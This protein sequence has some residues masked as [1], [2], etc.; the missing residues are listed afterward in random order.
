MILILDKR[1]LG[2]QTVVHNVEHRVVFQNR[3][4]QTDF[5]I[6]KKYV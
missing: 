1:L 3:S 4:S 5:L 6:F 2:N